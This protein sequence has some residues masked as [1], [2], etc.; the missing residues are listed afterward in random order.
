VL[1][2]NAANRLSRPPKGRSFLTMDAG[3]CLPEMSSRLPPSSA[4]RFRRLLEEC[5]SIGEARALLNTMKRTGLNS[6]VVA[7]RAG[8][9]VFEITPDR[10]VV[11][12]PED[13]ACICT[14]HFRTRELRPR[15]T[16]NLFKTHDHFTKLEQATCQREKFGVTDLHAALHSVCDP[17][18]TLQTMILAPRKLQLHLAIGTIPASAGVLRVVELGPFLHGP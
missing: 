18:I 2:I 13:G 12:G 11:R 17:E 15:T 1:V 3:L 8:V 4:R 16:L 6:L 9:A 14:N 7:D 10:V 5:S